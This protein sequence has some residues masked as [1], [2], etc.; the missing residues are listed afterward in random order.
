MLG[1][2]H[3][4]DMIAAFRFLWRDDHIRGTCAPS[5]AQIGSVLFYS[6]SCAT[7]ITIYMPAWVY[8]HTNGR[9]SATVHKCTLGTEITSLDLLLVGS[10]PLERRSSWCALFHQ[11]LHR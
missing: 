2:N 8:W 1:I 5:L 9:W 3:V 11:A 7:S 4:P 10:L 6:M